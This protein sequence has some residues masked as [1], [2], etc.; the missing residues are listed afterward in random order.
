MASTNKWNV[1]DAEFIKT[2][3]GEF[4]SF[5]V[6]SLASALTDT[7]LEALIEAALNEKGSRKPCLEPT[8]AEITIARTSKIGAIREYKVRTGASLKDAK[9]AV[10]AAMLKN[11]I[12][13]Q[14]AY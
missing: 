2:I 13:L 5:D 3:D 14:S 12:P 4:L 10:E 6:R 7:E 1:R 8:E 11:G 9:D